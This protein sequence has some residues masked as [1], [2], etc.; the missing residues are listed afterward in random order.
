M[1]KDKLS[2]KEEALPAEARRMAAARKEPPAAPVPSA[3]QSAP[4]PRP[5]SAPP[6]SAPTMAD[7]LARIMEDER[8]ETQ[9]RKKRMRRNGLLISAGILAVFALWL[10]SA[11]RRRR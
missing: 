9:E 4:A 7:R 11:F 8:A 2:P 6:A 5:A 3:P 10:L 1:E